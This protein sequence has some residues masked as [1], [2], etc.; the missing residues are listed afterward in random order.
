MFRAGNFD[1]VRQMLADDMKLDLVARLKI[2]GREKIGQYFTRYAQARHW[3]FA[4]GSV[5][6]APAM[7][8]LQTGRWLTGAFCGLS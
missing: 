3:R 1:S 5:D 6:G 4:A 8:D 2:H 7:L